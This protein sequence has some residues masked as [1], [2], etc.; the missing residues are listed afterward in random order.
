M[1]GL[2]LLA[3]LGEELQNVPAIII[4]GKGSEERI[5]PSIEAGAFWYIEKPLKGAVLRALLDRALGAFAIAGRWRH[6][7]G[8]CEMRED[9]AIW[10]ASRKLC[11]TL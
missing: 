11:R 6:S 3:R 1:N 7:H 2:D 5:I 9:W 8:N 10:S 4:T